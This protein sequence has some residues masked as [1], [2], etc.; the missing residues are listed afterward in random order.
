[1]RRNLEIPGPLLLSEG[2]VAA[3]APLLGADGKQK[4]QAVVDETLKAPAAEQSRIYTK[5]LRE[6]VP[7][8]KLS[9]AELEALLDPAN[10]LGEAA[11]I[12]RRILAA[13]PDFTGSSSKGA[14]RG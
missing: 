7:A 8:D 10:Y 1:M 12:S 13:Y 6:T 14:T 3:V 9:D 11:E 5:L 4:L 2:V